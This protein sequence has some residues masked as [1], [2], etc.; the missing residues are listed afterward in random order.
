MVADGQLSARSGHS[1]GRSRIGCRSV[2]LLYEGV[3]P[4]LKVARLLDIAPTTLARQHE[5]LSSDGS[6]T[7]DQHDRICSSDR[8]A[9]FRIGLSLDWETPPV[10]EDC[11]PRNV[12][13]PFRSLCNSL[14]VDRKT[15]PMQ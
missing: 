5:M 3:G 15:R 4:Q 2:D 14:R 13:S 6:T 9:T 10:K 12:C 8:V 7:G 1:S 11:V